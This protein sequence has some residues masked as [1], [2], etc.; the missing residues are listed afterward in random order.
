MVRILWFSLL[1]G[2]FAVLAPSSAKASTDHFSKNVLGNTES[3][4]DSHHIGQALLYLDQS[5]PVNLK[6]L[7]QPFK[8]QHFAKARAIDL[9]MRVALLYLDYEFTIIPGLPMLTLMY[10]YHYF[11]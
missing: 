7:F 11:P 5:L 9:K 1:L 6:E 4:N 8:K 3:H 10:P 2:L